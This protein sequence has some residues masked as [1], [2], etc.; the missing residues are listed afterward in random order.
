M[1]LSQ[2]VADG[3]AEEQPLNRY[4]ALM[5]VREN[6]AGGMAFYPQGISPLFVQLQGIRW[7]RLERTE[8]FIGRDSES[9]DLTPRFL[10]FQRYARAWLAWRRRV[11]QWLRGGR[12]LLKREC[13]GPSATHRL[14]SDRQE[15]VLLLW[16][17]KGLGP[18]G[19]PPSSPAR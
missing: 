18:P 12:G 11:H 8:F 3:G 7:F 15:L 4:Y 2:G 19:F 17:R 14:Q 13:E 10:A 5:L 6:S 16:P 1:P 9:W